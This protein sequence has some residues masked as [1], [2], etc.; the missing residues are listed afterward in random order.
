MP[1]NRREFQGAN[2]YDVPGGQRVVSVTTVLDGAWPNNGW[3]IPY[4]AKW[5]A[6]RL[7]STEGLRRIRMLMDADEDYSAQRNDLL[8]WG[9]AGPT[10][11]RD[12]AGDHG[13]D[14]HQYLERR[15]TG[16][17]EALPERETFSGYHAVEQF[18]A[19][20]RPEP[21]YIE[22]QVRSVA[23]G[24][25]GS[26]DAIVDIYGRR[27]L[28]DL[29]TS[30]TY[31]PH[32][33]RPSKAGGDHKDRLQLAAYRYADLIFE[34]GRDISYLPEVDACVVLAIPRDHPQAWRPI[35]VRAG[36]EE[37]RRFLGLLAAWKWHN[38]NKDTPIG[39][40]LL[41]QA[42]VA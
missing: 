31:D 41:P 40:H 3:R 23:E 10:E 17:I 22:A 38:D 32:V 9:K 7:L 25:A 36:M 39:E 18:L 16:A 6:E 13:T 33:E 28:L 4:G 26:F 21:V 5:T 34:D 8:K 14:L 42:E 15:L 1:K 20:Y 11:R 24:Y 30:Q 2:Y 35:E 27:V 19:T 29:K 37:H 12:V